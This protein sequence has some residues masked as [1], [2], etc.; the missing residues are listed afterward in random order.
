LERIPTPPATRSASGAREWPAP[1]ALRES[2][3]T[4]DRVAIDVQDMVGH[5][6]GPL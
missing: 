5:E 3:G 2:F 1:K 4:A 6:S